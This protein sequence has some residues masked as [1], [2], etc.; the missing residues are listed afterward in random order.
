MKQ[1]VDAI[2]IPDQKKERRN[3]ILVVTI[4]YPFDTITFMSSW[5]RLLT[6]PLHQEMDEAKSDN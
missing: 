1:N 2:I 5:Q 4:Y 6:D 3:S